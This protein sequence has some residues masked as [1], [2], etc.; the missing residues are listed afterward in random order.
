VQ[1][2]PLKYRTVFVAG[3]IAGAALIV[4]IYILVNAI[5]KAQLITPPVQLCSEDNIP[6][7][8]YTTLLYYQLHKQAPPSFHAM[9]KFYPQKSGLPV[10]DQNGRGIAYVESDIFPLIPE[11]NRGNHRLIIG[12]NGLAYYTYDHYETFIEITASCVAWFVRNA[13]EF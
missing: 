7:A 8:A 6:R 1:E 13:W 2:K 12:D 9:K 5:N 11:V 4:F 10:T 3:S